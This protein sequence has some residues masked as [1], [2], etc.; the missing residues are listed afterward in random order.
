MNE[1]AIEA[2]ALGIINTTRD[3]HGLDLI[4]WDC[5]ALSS[6]HKERALRQAR[7]A[8]SA[9]QPHMQASF[10]GDIVEI[11]VPAR[12]STSKDGIR[13]RGRLVDV[14]QAS[15]ELTDPFQHQ[16]S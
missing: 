14:P 9:A 2:A 7:S 15:D 8:L 3:Y 13:Y 12:S 4:A 1:K 5:P 11:E 6:W 10:P 16:L